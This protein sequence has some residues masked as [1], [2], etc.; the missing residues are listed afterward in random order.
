MIDNEMTLDKAYEIAEQ[1]SPLP[2]LASQALRCMRAEIER[3]QPLLHADDLARTF[4]N[5]YERL[6]PQFGYE[7]RPETR[8]FD[9][10]TPNGQLMIA[11]C[12]R[13]RHHFDTVPRVDVTD[14]DVQAA[15]EAIHDHADEIEDEAQCIRCALITF[16]KRKVDEA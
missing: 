9:P 3:L 6:A 2:H 12:K 15:I 14:E 4:H 11:V 16:V 5:A 1:A 7:T 10:H 13:L 8:E